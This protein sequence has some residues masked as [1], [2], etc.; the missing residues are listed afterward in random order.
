MFYI[1]LRIGITNTEQL[2]HQFVMIPMGMRMEHM[3][4]DEMH[5]AAFY[6]YD[7]VAPR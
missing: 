7:S 4:V 3:S 6:I 1:S 2:A 5:Q